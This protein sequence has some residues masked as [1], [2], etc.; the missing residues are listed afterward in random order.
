MGKIRLLW[1]QTRWTRPGSYDD[2]SAYQTRGL[3]FRILASSA[4]SIVRLAAITAATLLSDVPDFF[5][6]AISTDH[7]HT[8]RSIP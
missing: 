8:P 5:L 4:L 1:F 7:F 6:A 2:A 3:S